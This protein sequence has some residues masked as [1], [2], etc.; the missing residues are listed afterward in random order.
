MDNLKKT[1]KLSMIFADI[2][3]KIIIGNKFIEP[4]K[5]P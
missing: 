3:A 1:K 4:T 2:D 5:I